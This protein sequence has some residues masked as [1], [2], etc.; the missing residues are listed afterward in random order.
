MAILLVQGFIVGLKKTFPRSKDD[1]RESKI[2]HMVIICE[3]I[4]AA[5]KHVPINFN[6]LCLGY[7]G[8]CR[9]EG[10]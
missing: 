10:C 8:L 1:V 2:Q 6:A 9:L 4:I 5:S 7:S 3:E